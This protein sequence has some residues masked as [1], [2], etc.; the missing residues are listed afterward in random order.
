MVP[1]RRVS[2]RAVGAVGELQPAST[3][4]HSIAGTAGGCFVGKKPPASEKF[5]RLVRRARGWGEEAFQKKAHQP[6]GAESRVER[7]AD[8]KEC[9]PQTLRPPDGA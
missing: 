5:P 7:V 6:S 9:R 2:P 3:D 4:E 8:E 1:G